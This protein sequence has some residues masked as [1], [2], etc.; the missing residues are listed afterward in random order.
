MER[1][2]FDEFKNWINKNGQISWE[3]VEMFNAATLSEEKNI[4][5][6]E[7]KKSV[8]TTA[9]LKK[10]EE[11]GYLIVPNAISKSDCEATVDLIYHTLGMDK[12]DSSSWY[13]D[14]PLLQGIMVQLFR[15]PLLQQN[16]LSEKI[17]GAFQELWQR[18]N[19]MVSMDR[20]S[21]NPPETE[22][23]Q[24]PGPN[25]HWDVSLKQP[26]PFG[27]Q[28]L[29]YLT[30]TEANQ[31]AFTLVPGFHNRI[32]SWL[33]G[34]PP[35]AIPREQDLNALGTRPIAAKA[36]DFVIWHHAL[37]HGSSPNTSTRPRVVQYINYQ[38]IDR[39]IQEEWI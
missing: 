8:L 21:F 37:P 13:G 24:F 34:L 19:L 6:L 17:R 7:V 36:G 5:S 26:I 33:D 15:H 27:L 32:N 29:L 38:P 25:L 23:Y 31:G 10:W 30:D 35:N 22:H 16:R 9:N 3:M 14:H 20:V 28:G 2:S 39:E 4:D 1:P 12:N 18:N 11:D